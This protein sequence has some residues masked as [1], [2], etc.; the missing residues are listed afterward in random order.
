[1]ETSTASRFTGPLWAA[2][3]VSAAPS[4]GIGHQFG[5]FPG[6]F[7]SG[8]LATLPLP[9]GRCRPADQPVALL[10]D[11]KEFDRSADQG[12]INKGYAAHPR[13]MVYEDINRGQDGSW[14]SV[15]ARH[16]GVLSGSSLAVVCSAFESRCGDESLGAHWD[17]WTG[18]I[19]QIRGA[20]A[21]Q[22][23]HG[24]FD[25]AGPVQDV[26]TRAGDIL[27]LP[28]YL[29]HSVTT[30]KEPGYSLHLTFAVHREDRH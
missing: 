20:K 5:Y 27:I 15:V 2:L 7:S 17:A 10:A 13:T 22:I 26:L 19:V 16:L 29:P 3:S 18:A 9:A 24:V 1:M 6:A 23:G 14:H 12:E 25:K 28:K 8:W 4:A 30:P 21:W 11:T